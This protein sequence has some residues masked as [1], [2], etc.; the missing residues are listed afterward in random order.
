M[1][2]ES[3]EDDTKKTLQNKQTKKHSRVSGVVLVRV[4]VLRVCVR[5]KHVVVLVVL[6]CVTNSA[7]RQCSH[8]L[9]FQLCVIDSVVVSATYSLFTCMCFL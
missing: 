9:T 5:V 1:C 7:R 4:H 2:K 8:V 3:D 6:L